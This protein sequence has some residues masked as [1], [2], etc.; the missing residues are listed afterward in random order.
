MATCQVGA[1]VFQVPRLLHVP[2]VFLGLIGLFSRSFL[3]CKDRR[4]KKLSGRRVGEESAFD[5][6]SGDRARLFALVGWRQTRVG[7][8]LPK[9]PTAIFGRAEC[10]RI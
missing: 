9:D 3:T 4:G 2:A 8:S 10:P 5:R 7:I 1:L 6:G